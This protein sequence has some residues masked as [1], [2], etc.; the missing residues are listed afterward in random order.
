MA[1][2]RFKIE[3]KLD[4]RNFLKYLENN[5]ENVLS[6]LKGNDNREVF[7]SFWKKITSAAYILDTSIETYFIDLTTLLY[8]L[9]NST[10]SRVKVSL[11]SMR[12]SNSSKG[13]TLLSVDNAV[14]CDL[15]SF[16]KSKDLSLSE[17]LA[18]L[19]KNIN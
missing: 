11:R 12:K 15:S 16:A 1:R 6:D 9:P 4:K 14:H 8:M 17:A 3:T 13:K 10:I 5:R 7:V 18:F 19:L 2:P